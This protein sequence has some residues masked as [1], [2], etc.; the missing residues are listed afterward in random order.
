MVVYKRKLSG[1]MIKLLFFLLMNFKIIV[2]EDYLLMDS[3]QVKVLL[4]VLMPT[5]L[6]LIYEQ[7]L[8]EIVKNLQIQHLVQKLLK[9]LLSVVLSTPLFLAFDALTFNYFFVF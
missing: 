6:N 2:K 1:V 9:I 8:V 4:Y 3:I 5:L 7:A